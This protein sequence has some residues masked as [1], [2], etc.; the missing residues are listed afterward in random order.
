MNISG[1][2]QLEFE[3]AFKG[4]GISINVGPNSSITLTEGIE[5]PNFFINGGVSL[6]ATA[7]ILVSGTRTKD[8]NARM[9]AEVSCITQPMKDIGSGFL[10][11]PP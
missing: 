7:M 1:I 10:C 3:G 2:G 6:S 5:N 4:E 9:T 11:P 8:F